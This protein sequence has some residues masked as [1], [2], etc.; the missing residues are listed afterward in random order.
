VTQAFQV[1]QPTFVLSSTSALTALGET[2]GGIKAT[3]RSAALLALDA[4]RN[5]NP[6]QRLQ[7]QVS[8][9]HELA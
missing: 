5:Q 3:T 4:F 9:G 2:A 8:A 1:N 7:V 6:A